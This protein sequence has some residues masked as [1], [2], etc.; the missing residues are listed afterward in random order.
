MTRLQKYWELAIGMLSVR[1]LREA[2][3][4]YKKHA[5]YCETTDLKRVYRE[6]IEGTEQEVN[7]E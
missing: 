4:S 6:Y 5:K 1:R 2:V 3:N 7:C